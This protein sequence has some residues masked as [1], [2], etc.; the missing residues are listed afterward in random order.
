[1]FFCKNN[2]KGIM[3]L[4]V[5]FVVGFFGLGLALT[6]TMVA[7]VGLNKNYNTNSGNQTFYTAEAANEEG[8]Y[9]YIA[10]SSYL[11]GNFNQSINNIST[12]SI[13]I[14]VT[15]SW[16]YATVTAEAENNITHREVINTINVFP[17]SLAFDYA[18]FSKSG[19]TLT[20]SA[21]TTGKLF[22]NGDIDINSNH[23]QIGGGNCGAFS[24]GDITGHTEIID[25][26]CTTAKNLPEIPPPIVNVDLSPYE[27]DASNTNTLFETKHSFEHNVDGNIMTGVMFASTT[28]AIGLSN[29]ATDLSG[30]I[31]TRGNLSITNGQ[32]ETTNP[33]YYAIVCKGDFNMAGGQIIGNIYVDGNFSI[34]G[35]SSATGILYIKGATTVGSG[36]PDI[37]G[38]IISIGGITDTSLAGSPQIIYDEDIV[39]AWVDLPGLSTTTSAAPP[40]IIGWQ[41]Q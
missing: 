5:I 2:D 35:N 21:S 28:N 32:Y 41:E 40:R 3:S 37:H 31:V 30:S 6:I 26:N 19:I 11:G 38:A 4:V 12:S 24:A 1:M 13:S 14:F 9:Q 34:S 23:V 8:I 33:N 39:D 18:I 25:S 7:L 15:S 10:S 22:S 20:G 36:T 29:P 27:T 16:P 17:E